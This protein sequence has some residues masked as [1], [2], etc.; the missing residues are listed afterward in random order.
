MQ[1]ITS[2]KTENENINYWPIVDDHI[3]IEFKKKR[4]EIIQEV[5][6][7]L[8]NIYVDAYEI[9]HQ[10]CENLYQEEFN[11]LKQNI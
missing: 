2:K 7:T 3:A 1:R 5:K 10:Q 6:R 4:Y 9:Q 11:K 8:L